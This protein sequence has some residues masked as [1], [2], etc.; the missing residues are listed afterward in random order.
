MASK[1][2]RK[3]ERA[4]MNASPASVNE[5]PHAGKRVRMSSTLKLMLARA[6]SGDHVT[7]FGDC[8]GVVEGWVFGPHCPEVDVRWQP[9]G[10]RWG[11][12]ID[13]LE[14]IP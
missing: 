5:C 14:V 2:E 8:I 6:G 10:L 9:S 3:A 1:R 13:Q 11:Y 4:A 12:S 7:E